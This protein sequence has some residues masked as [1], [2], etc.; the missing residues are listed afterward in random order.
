MLDDGSENDNDHPVT[1]MY[2]D[3]RDVDVDVGTESSV[4]D[5]ISRMSFATETEADAEVMRG[6]GRLR[7]KGSFELA[8]DQYIGRFD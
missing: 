1:N 8:G 2:A 3:E 7:R 6:I 4:A 5:C